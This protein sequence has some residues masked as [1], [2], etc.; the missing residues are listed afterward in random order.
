VASKS[1][2]A[3]AKQALVRAKLNP[4][5][6]AIAHATEIFDGLYQPLA[7]A[8]PAIAEITNASAEQE[9]LNLRPSMAPVDWS[10]FLVTATSSTSLITFA[11]ARR[12]S[13]GGVANPAAIVRCWHGNP[14]ALASVADCQN[15]LSLALVNN[16]VDKAVVAASILGTP[17][18]ANLPAL[19]TLVASGL[20]TTIN[21]IRTVSRLGGDVACN[22][23]MLDLTGAP[24]LKND[25]VSAFNLKAGT[26]VADALQ[27]WT[28]LSANVA[29]EQKKVQIVRSL[30]LAPS[31][32]RAHFMLMV[33]NYAA[34]M[35][36]EHIS[37]AHVV[38]LINA[39]MVIPK[40]R[41]YD[42]PRSGKGCVY[43]FEL[44]GQ[45]RLE[46]EW[47]IHFASA[48]GNRPANAVGTGWKNK[49][50]RFDQQVKTFTPNSQ[51]LIACL[52][53]A[54]AWVE[55]RF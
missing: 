19:T 39:G 41:Y 40:G 6:P 38:T 51:A 14:A 4:A 52:K 32:T 5:K 29:D 22:K 11:V 31:A 21:Q 8:A 28:L 49:S 47:H 1:D 35:D 16:D 20:F 42:S 26:T 2:A 45:G 25:E 55:V 33:Q 54:Q 48:G 15:V 46:P 24:G 36:R 3:M 50:E 53:T 18:I 10:P 12:A 27:C 44:A 7:F 43:V 9:L 13:L 17:Q 34:L 30:V 23:R 37:C